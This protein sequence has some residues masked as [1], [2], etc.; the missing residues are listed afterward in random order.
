[1]SAIAQYSVLLEFNNLNYIRYPN[2]PLINDGNV[3]YAVT[4]RGGLNSEGAI[5]KVNIDGT[6]LTNLYDFEYPLINPYGGLVLSG[7]TLYGV[8]EGNSLGFI[9]RINTDGSGFTVIK[10]FSSGNDGTVNRSLILDGN[11]LFGTG[12]H[13][14]AGGGSGQIFKIQTDGTGFS[15]I[16]DFG[17]TS[18]LVTP[19]PLTL[20]NTMFYGTTRYGGANNMG[21][22]YKVNMDGSGFVKLLDFSDDLGITKFNNPLTIINDIIYGTTEYG[23][24]IA[25]GTMYKINTDGTGFSKLL[26]FNPSTTGTAPLWALV[27]FNN[28]LFGVTYRGGL[29][30]EGVIYKVSPDGTGYETLQYF[31]YGHGSTPTGT[32]IIKDNALYGLGGSGGAG[33]C[34]VLFKYSPTTGIN[35]NNIIGL[36]QIFP[37]PVSDKFIFHCTDFSNNH[38][39]VISISNLQ[40]QSLLRLPVDGEFTMVDMRNYS[41]GIYFLEYRSNK[42]SRTVKIVKE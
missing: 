13:P 2:G 5:F 35:D 30:D 10:D 32:L 31:S 22:L 33:D 25:Y 15:R 20:Y 28:A 17:E 1:M 21:V 23:G 41:N 7:S 24:P 40:G 38:D 14:G 39:A 37:N 12:S 34:G 42:N 9:Y 29:A 4:N 11:Y 16:Y 8:G 26:D 27:S 36:C 18:D 3:F 19:G 6:G